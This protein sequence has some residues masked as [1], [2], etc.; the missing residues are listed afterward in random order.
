MYH[1]PWHIWNGFKRLCLYDWTESRNLACH[2][3]SQ[4]SFLLYTTFI[5]LKITVPLLPW[6]RKLFFQIFLTAHVF[7]LT[8]HSCVI[9]PFFNQFTFFLLSNTL[10]QTGH[11]VPPFASSYYRGGITHFCLMT[12]PLYIYLRIKFTFCITLFDLAL[13]SLLTWR[14]SCDCSYRTQGFFIVFELFFCL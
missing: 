2:N 7:E 5:S 12:L 8:D 4:W 3:L 11:D 10:F 14:S 13:W 6:V 1:V 9:C